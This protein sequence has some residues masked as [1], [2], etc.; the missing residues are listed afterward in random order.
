[1]TLSDKFVRLRAEEFGD[2]RGAYLDAASMTP[3]PTRSRIASDS[4]NQ[5]R[6]RAHAL[7]GEDFAQPIQRARQAC[8]GLIGADPNETAL[9]ANTSFGINIAALGLGVPDGT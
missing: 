1:M 9:G 7:T 4:F 8:A 2:L 5:A 3:L 6:I